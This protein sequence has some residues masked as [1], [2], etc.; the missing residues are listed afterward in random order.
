MEQLLRRI[1][2]RMAKGA[3]PNET[4]VSMGV[5]LPVLRALGWDET[6]PQEVFPEYTQAGKR[7]D[8]ALFGHPGRPSV[9]IEVKGVGR[10]LDGDR[11]LFEYAFHE[12]IPMCVLTNGK[13]WSFYL[14]SGQGSYE[15][16]RVFRLQLTDRSTADCVA[17]LTRYLS[18]DRVRN[19]DALEDA[20]RDY[21]DLSASRHAAR[22]LPEAWSRLIGEPEDLLVE[23]LSEQTEKISGHRPSSAEVVAFLRRL[24]ETSPVP[25]NSGPSASPASQAAGRLSPSPAHTLPVVAS[26]K[27]LYSVFGDH[28]TA[29]TA[30]AAFLDVL[31]AVAQRSPGKIEAIAA[32]ARGRSRN[33]IAKSADEIY[34]RRPDLAR[35]YEFTPGWLVGL[36]I[37]NREKVRIVREAC[38]AAGV[39]FGTDVTLD[40]PNAD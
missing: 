24:T 30:N 22:S 34:P 7:V 3:Y 21:R 6:D 25:R 5:V 16:R 23:L 11:Q 14:P 19:G 15:E 29:A 26:G 39:R 2:D 1:Q 33:H 35:A 38:R 37:A 28:R 18:R 12:G 9:F 36:N 8:F 40:L 27:I 17:A 13:E 20:N 4:S 32:A 10:S 31:S